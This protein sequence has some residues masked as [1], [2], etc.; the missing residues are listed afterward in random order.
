M[1]GVMS[2]PSLY[3][4]NTSYSATQWMWHTETDN[5]GFRSIF[6][7]TQ[8]SSIAST[9]GSRVMAVFLNK[10]STPH[11]LRLTLDTTTAAMQLIP[12]FQLPVRAR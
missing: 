4:I 6:Q 5:T 1:Q 12:D 7:I 10:I 8:T 11:A 9:V 3:Q 2:T